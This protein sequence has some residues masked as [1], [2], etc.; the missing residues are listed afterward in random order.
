MSDKTTKSE[1]KTVEDVPETKANIASKII[2]KKSRSIRPRVSYGLKEKQFDR[3]GE[4]RRMGG[5]V[6]NF[7]VDDEFKRSQ[8][9]EWLLPVFYRQAQAGVDDVGANSTLC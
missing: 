4:L 8:H 6:W 9:Y 3:E 7:N 1:V 5:T 2:D